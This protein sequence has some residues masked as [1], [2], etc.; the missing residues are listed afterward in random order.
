MSGYRIVVFCAAVL[1]Q[2]CLQKEKLGDLP[3]AENQVVTDSGRHFVS[4]GTGLMEVT[5]TGEQWQLKTVHTACDEY[6]G[7]VSSGQ[8]LLAICADAALVQPRHQLIA[9]RLHE[10]GQTIQW[11]SVYDFADMTLPNGMALGQDGRSL[12]VADYVLLGWGKLAKYHVSFDDERVWVSLDQLDFLDRDQGVYS[13]NGVRWSDGA[14]YLTDFNW[15]S[16]TSR[17]LKITLDSEGE[18]VA[19]TTLYEKATILDDL[20]PTCGGVLVGDFLNG[21]LVFINSMGEVHR[22]EYQAYPG[23][24]SVRWGQTPLFDADTL[25]ITERGIIQ[26]TVS[27]IGNQVSL[28]HVSEEAM[29]GVGAE[30]P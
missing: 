19:F 13:P 26:D 17:V 5:S 1:L 25:V 11:Q 23:I 30:C 9:G 4:S 20:L 27:A 3:E 2:G 24:S 16:L 15:S 14:L 7:L 22:S 10:D 8:W 18:F 21:R 29:D 28:V 6:N 12:Y